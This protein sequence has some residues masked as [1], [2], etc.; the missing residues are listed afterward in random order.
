M[1]VEHQH[2][3]IGI[4]TAGLRAHSHVCDRNNQSINRVRVII[5]V[6]CW[7]SEIISGFV[8]CCACVRDASA[9]VIRERHSLGGPHSL[10]PELEVGLWKTPT[11][12]FV[13]L[14]RPNNLI[15]FQ[16]L[17]WESYCDS[18]LRL[19]YCRMP[20]VCSK[21]CLWSGD[22]NIYDCDRSITIF[23][24]TIHKS[25]PCAGALARLRS[26]WILWTSN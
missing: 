5:I 6:Y 11:I 9:Q 19:I 4:L 23:L 26:K 21:K 15:L 24:S 20:K 13:C 10:P 25:I 16:F 22:N 3:I 8:R 12:F 17:D 14:L 7:S 1:G 2:H 18:N